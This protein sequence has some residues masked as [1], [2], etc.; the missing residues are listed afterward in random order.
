MLLFEHDLK[1]RLLIR[2]KNGTIML[3]DLSDIIE[4]IHLNHN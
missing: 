4:K 3:I 2:F 1:K